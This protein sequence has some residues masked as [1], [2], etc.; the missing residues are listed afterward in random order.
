MTYCPPKEQT[1]GEVS[2]PGSSQVDSPTLPRGGFWGKAPDW[3]RLPVNVWY[4]ESG[5]LDERIP[6]Q[7]PHR[8]RVV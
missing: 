2:E 5:L 8:V 6:M 4:P 7:F 3:C 1:P